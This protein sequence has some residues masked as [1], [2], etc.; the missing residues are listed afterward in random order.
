MATANHGAA[1]AACITRCAEA[2]NGHVR[3]WA[4]ER[5]ARDLRGTGAT[6]MI[7]KA[8]AEA[9]DAVGCRIAE[10][11]HVGVGAGSGGHAGMVTPASA[12][13]HP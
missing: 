8:T 10:V 9:A 2:E 5:L 4:R 6:P 3:R 7:A 11:M 12:G 13:A 1:I